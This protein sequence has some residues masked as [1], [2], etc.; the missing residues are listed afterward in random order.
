MLF[1]YIKQPYRIKPNNK[2][3]KQVYTVFLLFK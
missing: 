2:F 3:V 1:V